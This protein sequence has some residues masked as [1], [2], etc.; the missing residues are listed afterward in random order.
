VTG[1]FLPDASFYFNNNTNTTISGIPFGN[2]YAGGFNFGASAGAFNFNSSGGTAI[3]LGGGISNSSA[4]LQTFNF[5]IDP[6]ADQTWNGG[7]GGLKL[8]NFDHLDNSLTLVNKVNLVNLGNTS[9]KV[10]NTGTGILNIST[11]SS[12]AAPELIIGEQYSGNG[13]VNL[14][15]S[16]ASLNLGG[17]LYMGRSGTG[18]LNITAGQV[19]AYQAFLGFNY[20]SQ[21][22]VLID[23]TASKLAITSNLE[24][25]HAST[26]TLTV[27]NGGSLTSGNSFLGRALGGDGLVVLTGAGSSWVSSGNL[28]IGEA[29]VGSLRVEAGA[30]LSNVSATL[31]NLDGSLG[32]AKVTGANSSWQLSG[33]V[34]IGNLGEGSLSIESGGLLSNQNTFV[35]AIGDAGSSRLVV[36]G[37]G[38]R[39][40]S[41]GNLSIQSG[42]QGVADASGVVAPNGGLEITDGGLVSVNQAHFG[43][44]A[45]ATALV[46]L[47]GT[48][49]TLTAASQLTIGGATGTA[50]VNLGSGATININ[51][52]GQLVI[53]TGGVLNLNGGTLNAGWSANAGKFNWNSGTVNFIGSQTSGNG[54]LEHSVGLG[55]GMNMTVGG[56]LT[57]NAGDDLSLNGGQAQALQL[58]MAGDM[59]VGSF[60]QLTI[61]TGGA[62]VSGAL[63]LA[64]GTVFTVGAFEN[65]GY[66][67]GYGVITGL[68]GFTNSGLLQQG[69]GTLLLSNSGA[70]LNTGTWAL[71][72]GRNLSLGADLQN[73]GSFNLNGGNVIGTGVLYNAA[74]GTISGNGRIASGFVNLG[75]LVVDQGRT[76]VDQSFSNR[77]QILLGANSATL[78][79]GQVGNHGLI[80][81][82]GKITANISNIDPV[83]VIEAQGGTLT[84]SGQIVS[85]N[86]GIL[87]AD[88]GAKLLISQGLASNAGKIQLAGGTLD[89]NGHALSNE[90][91][92][93]I[94]GY[95]TLR[96]GLLTNK[97]QLF[98]SGGNSAVYTQLLSTAGSQIIVSGLSNTTFYGKVDVQSGAEL[99]VSEGSVATFGAL[100]QQ[101]TGSDFNGDGLMLFEGGLS[102]GASPGLGSIAGSVTF[103]SSNSYLAEIGG[104]TACTLLCGTDDAIKNSSFDKLVVGG[105][106]KLGG[107]LVLTSWNGF[108]AQKGQRFDLFDWGSSSG[109][110]KTIDASGFKLAAG[111]QLDYSALYT[112]GEVFVTT[113]A[114]PEPETYAMLLAGL[115]VIGFLA[116]R[117]RAV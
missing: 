18:V 61:G 75:T 116:R 80:Q 56:I 90:V 6:T 73:S 24:V 32:V 47:S 50:T 5:H 78:A 74:D 102:V 28:S 53:G 68:S 103:T 54:I 105:K 11:S 85:P 37:A 12:L 72:A 10:G 89:N 92:G 67:S 1:G 60:S 69:D 81:G 64:G 16:N 95:G 33:N 100:V 43:E 94:S 65:S 15:S 57:I 99:R 88:S 35:G 55:V 93:V 111:T 110:F 41:T 4:N 13:T 83:A 26:G 62:K 114:V 71:Q 87:V 91:A 113:S 17:S 51:S 19:S 59:G 82:V 40:L 115:G 97:G 77:G 44:S 30:K 25:G 9:T 66:V 14:T 70:N 48:G 112:T 79:G 39:L 84:L 23:G 21:G 2:G 3:G 58:V 101:R 86:G 7:T 107:T 22:T 8:W 38:S 29:G 104:T 20:A 106:L 49:S 36:T 42:K 34:Q 63:G 27:Q 117:R 31:G 46:N 96:G 108:V 52:T 98:L 76:Q 45:G 109:S